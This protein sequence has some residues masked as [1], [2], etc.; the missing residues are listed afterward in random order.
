[1][2]RVEAIVRNE[3]VRMVKDHLKELGI[4][5][6]IL[7]ASVWSK[8]RKLHL[9]YR[10]LPVDYDLIPAA[11]FELIV[12]DEMFKLVVK[13]IKE[14]ATTGEVEDGIIMVSNLDEAVEIPIRESNDWH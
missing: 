4:G 13:T 8:H 5:G 1:M 6:I 9:R 11:K 3:R 10:G 14:N 2:K 12:P 7:H